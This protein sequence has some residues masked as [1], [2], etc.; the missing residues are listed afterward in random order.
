MHTVKKLYAIHI[1]T[2]YS[3]NAGNGRQ[4]TPLYFA[5]MKYRPKTI[6]LLL[7]HGAGIVAIQSHVD[8]IIKH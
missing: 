6:Q 7:K 4:E 3:L 5:A 8:T 2:S 1:R